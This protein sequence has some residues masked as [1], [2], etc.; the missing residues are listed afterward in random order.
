MA[1]GTEV[2][3]MPMTSPS[4]SGAAE[5]SRG[6]SATYCSPSADW[7][8]TCAVRFEGMSIPD[9]SDSTAATPPFSLRSTDPTV[10]DF[11]T[12]VGDDGAGIQA[13]GGRQLNGDGV[14][15]DTQHRRHPDVPDGHYGSRHQSNDGEYHQLNECTSVHSH[16]WPL[17]EVVGRN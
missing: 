3:S 10:A 2:S 15:T 17:I 7:L 4:F 5:P 11:G 12:A 9:C 6:N 14:A 1:G 13:A 16:L 8:C